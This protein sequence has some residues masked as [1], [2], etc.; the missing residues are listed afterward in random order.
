[1]D[2]K[3][4]FIAIKIINTD[5]IRKIFRQVQL[6]LKDEYIKW[7]DLK[8]LHITLAF[9]GATDVRKI[10]LIKNRLTQCAT[11]FPP[12]Q[13]QIKSVG[14]F[15]SIQ[16]ARVLWLGVETENTIFDL[17]NKILK[18]LEYI[19]EISDTRFSPHVTIGRIKHGVKNPDMVKEKLLDHCNWSDDKIQI[20]EFVLMESKTTP[21][22]PVYDVM[23]S[24][25][26]NGC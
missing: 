3:R 1:M 8:G 17:R 13:I 16:R 5:Q 26:L 22:G 6:D 7:V 10:G 14:A 2:T 19:V 25:I 15:P 24:F 9:I 23:E 21:T 18:Q 11:K 12:F 4:I 20:S